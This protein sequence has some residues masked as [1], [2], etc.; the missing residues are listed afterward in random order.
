MF[1]WHSRLG[2]PCRDTKRTSERSTVIVQQTEP[3]LTVQFDNTPSISVSPLHTGKQKSGVP[4]LL[5][6]GSSI[7]TA[8]SST[9]KNTKKVTFSLCVE[10]QTVMLNLAPKF[11]NTHLAQGIWLI[12][13]TQDG[14]NILILLWFPNKIL[15]Y[16]NKVYSNYQLYSIFLLRRKFCRP[17]DSMYRL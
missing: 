8:K 14:K 6:D 9:S 16:A 10:A 12:L 3:V 4:T 5:P 2:I 11:H 1:A 15:I 13:G 17:C 7:R